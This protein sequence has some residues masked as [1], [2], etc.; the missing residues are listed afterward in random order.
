MTKVRRPHL[1]GA[2]TRAI[3]GR[4]AQVHM[5]ERKMKQDCQQAPLPCLAQQKFT[6]RRR[7]QLPTLRAHQTRCLNEL[8]YDLQR[9]EVWFIDHL[10]EPERVGL[11]IIRRC[12]ERAH[13]GH[14]RPG[15]VAGCGQRQAAM[16]NRP[17]RRIRVLRAIGERAISSQLRSLAIRI[18]V[19]VAAGSCRS[20]CK[21]SNV[22]SVQAGRARR[23]MLAPA[24]PRGNPE[25]P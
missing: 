21:L 1:S 24:N 18:A 11:I 12:H 6:Q 8:T 9:Q 3:R 10:V 13:F 23:A 17:R 16:G 14:H 2:R 20:A 25:Q 7:H 22:R 15:Q 5:P 19:R 4:V